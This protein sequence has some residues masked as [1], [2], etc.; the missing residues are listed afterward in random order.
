MSSEQQYELFLTHFTRDR[1]RLFRYIFSLLPNHADAEDVFQRCSL[2]LWRKFSN[3]DSNRNFLSWSCGIAL[4]EVRN[5][6]RSSHRHQLTFNSDLVTQL[7]CSKLQ[8]LEDSQDTTRH[9]SVCLEQLAVT[10]RELV[11]VIYSGERTVKEFAESTGQALQTLYNK[12]GRIRRQLLDCIRRK[13]ALES[14]L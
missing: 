7:S 8:E 6:L 13:M 10:E 12:L 5:F 11:E 1:E 4:H 14:P 3:F 2:V 9:L